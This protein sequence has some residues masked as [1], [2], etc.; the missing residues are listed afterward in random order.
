MGQE[1][2]SILVSAKKQKEVKDLCRIS[3]IT[4]SR[5]NFKRI[6]AKIIDEETPVGETNL[7]S[8]RSMS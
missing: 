4:L 6:G 3:N 5:A 8:I 7:I 1:N 2:Q